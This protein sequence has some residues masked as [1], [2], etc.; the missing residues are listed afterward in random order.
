MSL[1]LGGEATEL[2]VRSKGDPIGKDCWCT[3][4]DISAGYGKVS[5]AVWKEVVVSVG[6]QEIMLGAPSTDS[7]V[8]MMSKVSLE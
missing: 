1:L 4:C 6:E 7:S 2:V 3:H 5:Q 8:S